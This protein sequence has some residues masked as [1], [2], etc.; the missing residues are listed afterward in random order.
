MSVLTLD[1]V[2][3]NVTEICENVN[4]RRMS[5]GNGLVAMLGQLVLQVAAIND[6]SII[7]PIAPGSGHPMYYPI[8]EKNESVLASIV[9]DVSDAISDVAES[10]SDVTEVIADVANLVSLKS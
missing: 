7:R 10:V 3:K 2:T 4:A 5:E 9:E 8:E 6:R 1:E